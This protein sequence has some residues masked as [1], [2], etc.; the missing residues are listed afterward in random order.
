LL[1]VVAAAR[2]HPLIGMLIY[3]APLA[4]LVA[5]RSRSQRFTLVGDG[6]RLIVRH[7]KGEQETREQ[8]VELGRIVRVRDISDHILLELNDG[9]TVELVV[10]L[11]TPRSVLRWLVG[12]L[13][14]L[15][16][17]A[18]QLWPELPEWAEAPFE[19]DRQLCP[20]EACI[21]IIGPDGR[22]KVCG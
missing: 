22:C 17:H 5:R 12:R 14:W 16:R 1:G 19:P 18:P 21:G 4:G 3:L 11:N 9:T 15:A 2:H 10:G 7:F 8:V 13:R 6:S 20:D